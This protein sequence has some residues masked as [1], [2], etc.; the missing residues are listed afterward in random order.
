MKKCLP[1]L[2]IAVLPM[3]MLYPL[4]TDPVSAGEDDVMFFYPARVMVGQALRAGQWPL[5]DP[6]EGTGAPLMADP[7]SAVLHPATWL[8]AVLEAPLAYSLS[9]FIAFA[10]AGAGAYL[11]LRTLALA[12]TASLFGAVAFMFCGF[13]VGHRVHLSMIMTAAMLGWMLWCIEQAG[14]R[15]LRAALVGAPVIFLAIAAGHWPT[16]VQMMLVCGAYFLLRARPFIRAA[17]A[18]LAAGVMAILAAAPQIAQTLAV[19]RQST[20][21]GIGY[22]TFGENSFFPL[23]AVMEF[24]PLI[25]GTRTPNGLYSQP[26]WGP[27]HL[28]ETLGYVGLATLVLAGASVWKLYRKSSPLAA[29]HATANRLVR[30]WTWIGLGA[31]VWMLGYYLPTYRLVHMVPGLSLVRCPSRMLLAVDMALATLAAVAVNHV[32]AARIRRGASVSPVSPTSVQAVGEAQKSM[33]ETPMPHNKSMGETPMPH[34]KSMGETP[35]PQGNTGKMPVLLMGETPMLRAIRRGATWVLP[36]VML[37]VLAVLAGLTFAMRLWM[38]QR[39][40][41]MAFMV[42]WADEAGKSLQP[43]S[44][45]IWVPLALTVLTILVV[46]AWLLLPQRRQPLLV[47]LLLADLFFITAFVDVPG[48]S[49]APTEPPA[50]VWLRE[51]GDLGGYRI[52]SLA[53]GYADRPAEL[54]RPRWGQLYG[55]ATI[56]SYGPLKSPVPSH[57]FGFG[58]TGETPAWRELLDDN[59]LLSA[60]GVKYILAA[61]PTFRR[62]VESVTVAPATGVAKPQAEIPGDNWQLDRARQEGGVLTLECSKWA[63]V[64]QIAQAVQDVPSGKGTYRLSFDARAPSGGAANVLGAELSDRRTMTVPAE[65]I[66]ADWRHFE[67][68]LENCTDILPMQ[69]GGEHDWDARAALRLYSMSER[70]IEVRNISLRAGERSRP[71]SWAGSP[72]KPGEAVYRLVTEVASLTGGHPPVAIYENRFCRDAGKIRLVDAGEAEVEAF[73]HGRGVID[74]DGNMLLPRLGPPSGGEMTSSAARGPAAGA[75]LW[76]AM[77]FSAII[78]KWRTVKQKKP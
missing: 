7:Q 27:W 49:K 10:L 34:N 77:A 21:T 4:W 43:G 60:Y 18:L 64:P 3:A 8:F 70:P 66:G 9:I 23:S 44:P 26:W 56:N 28:C 39:P 45:A 38:P 69:G 35:M 42:G 20:R 37:G 12:P 30:V 57:V 41:G 19:A 2:L 33:G 47:A 58:P 78:K 73:R 32:C 55:F 31:A 5:T 13:M 71:V 29:A 50:A 74:A 54:L 59:Y 62:H 52:W 36:A 63:P 22:L 67:A 48:G 16:L 75:V 68:T 14:P 11:Y 17:T 6:L 24:F 40:D 61:D 15:P 72:L 65:Q 1:W 46:R 76:V 53:S 51:H 25:F